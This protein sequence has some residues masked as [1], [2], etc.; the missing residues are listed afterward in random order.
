M[1]RHKT[2]GG[3]K[4]IGIAVVV[5]IA[6]FAVGYAAIS[7]LQPALPTANV[8][9]IEP[10]SPP[11][12]EGFEVYAGKDFYV[13]YPE[14]WKPRK[15]SNEFSA[16]EIGFV[17]PSEYENDTFRESVLITSDV[18][19]KYSLKDYA[20][21]SLLR[22]QTEVIPQFRLL[23]A[24]PRKIGNID[25]FQA[26]F[27]GNDSINPVIKYMQVYVPSAR[28]MYVLT[29]T[30]RE[31]NFNSFLGDANQIIDSFIPSK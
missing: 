27:A 3:M 4:S 25:G 6:F 30:S 29:Y 10:P 21:L 24:G 1:T 23:D 8:I 13:Y 16:V 5:L 26:V 17:A 28:K 2:T 20:T 19:G 31:K 18:L 7:L 14:D 9:N 12:K 15:I 22:L 11:E